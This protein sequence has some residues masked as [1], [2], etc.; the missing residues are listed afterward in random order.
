ME[1]APDGG[2]VQILNYQDHFMKFLVL[3]PLKSKRA[4]EVAYNLTESDIFTLIGAPCILQS[5]I[6]QE[7][8]ALVLSKLKRMWPHLR[9][10]YGHARHPQSQG[11]VE[12]SNQDVKQMLIAWTID[13][14]TT[15]WAE[16]LRFVQLHKNSSP[17]RNL[18]N[19]SPYEIL[20]GEKPRMGLQK[21]VPPKEVSD[22]LT[23]EELEAAL[24][25]MI[26]PDADDGKVTATTADTELEAALREMVG[27]D[28]DD[29]EVAPATANIELEAV[30]TAD[31]E[32][33][34]AAADFENQQAETTHSTGP[35]NVSD[36]DTDVD[37]EEIAREKTG[38]QEEDELQET[39]DDKRLTDN[40]PAETG[41]RQSYTCDDSCPGPIAEHI[42]NIGLCHEEAA[43]GQQKS[44]N[45][46]MASSNA[47]L[48]SLA[49]GDCVLLPVSEFNRGRLDTRNIPQGVSEVTEHG[50]YHA[51]TRHGVVNT[52][53][54]RNQLQLPDLEDT[55][56][57]VHSFCKI[58]SLHSALSGQSYSKCFCQSAC[59]SRQC[60]CK[61]SGTLCH[62][63]CHPQNSKC[64]N[65]Q[66]W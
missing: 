21:T 41:D 50:S 34:R 18:Q 60:A 39:E 36:M 55:V 64:K 66:L 24:R 56:P 17:H 8:V 52:T 29:G 38:H 6:G 14:N 32:Q 12:R 49:V 59:N 13:S 7:F 2:Y 9:I 47:N 33:E 11:S 51:A 44:Q 19:K 43:R 26:G 45:Q 61:K 53:Y 46:M 22:Q 23:M 25:E 30:A 65:K 5:D 3:R 15:K 54:S 40:A 35:Y 31:T 48:P 4:S 10:V 58:A 63:H 28:A 1:S 42:T 37:P 16:G 20:L 27:L 57:E 62:S